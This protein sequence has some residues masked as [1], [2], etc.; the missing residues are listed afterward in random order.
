MELTM[1]YFDKVN[2]TYFTL[3]KNRIYGYHQFIKSFNLDI[4]KEST[5]EYVDESLK[6][7][8]DLG[9]DSSDIQE[10]KFNLIKLFRNQEENFDKIQ[11]VIESVTYSINNKISD[12]NASI[13]GIYNDL[14]N[15][16]YINSILEFYNDYLNFICEES[17]FM[18]SSMESMYILTEADEK[19]V[20]DR[21]KEQR[22][23]AKL[24]NSNNDSNQSKNTKESISQKGREVFKKVWETIK[25]FFTKLTTLFSDKATKIKKK[26][27]D[28]LK[29]IDKR[30]K[31][32]DVSNIEIDVYE[33]VS[34]SYN[35]SVNKL[36][37]ITTKLH[38]LKTD[39]QIHEMS[40]IITDKYRDNNDNLKQGIINYM[41]TGN[42]KKEMSIVTIKG[43]QITST[44]ESM[45]KYCLDYI[46]DAGRLQK[47]IK[48]GENFAKRLEKEASRRNVATES[49]CFIEECDYTQTELILCENYYVLLEADDKK[50]TPGVRTV[51]DAKDIANNMDDKSLSSYTK[52][53]RDE[54]VVVSAL[55]TALEGRYFEY[56][57]I[58]RSL[59]K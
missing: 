29:G 28:W 18:V 46:S 54:Q 20:E 58:L 36:T 10:N 15:N 24:N 26:D 21:A 56:I 57:K 47:I 11:N 7:L 42:P 40:K 48:D 39:G 55:L 23:S 9:V 45:R 33:G 38:S 34:K 35:D 49:Y 14:A 5:M 44:L 6:L 52:A 4:L 51:G 59:I 1:E 43:S 41:R 53:V 3:E 13:E 8:S 2:E 17:L 50:E 22:P 25:A 12:F 32:L 16:T 27:E 19:T 37:P 30:I 31:Q